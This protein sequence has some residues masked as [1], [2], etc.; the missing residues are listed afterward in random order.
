[1]KKQK[2]IISF[3]LIAFN[4]NMHNIYIDVK[5]NMKNL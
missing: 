3:Y 5:K 4:L 2:K 1:M